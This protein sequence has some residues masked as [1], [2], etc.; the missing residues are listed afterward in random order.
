MAKRFKILKAALKT[1]I[2]VGAAADAIP[3]APPVGTILER[4]ATR[5]SRNITYATDADRSRKLD[6]KKVH[7]FSMVYSV[8]GVVL[9]PVSDKAMT[10]IA[11]YIGAVAILNHD[12]TTA[13]GGRFRGFEP[14]KVTVFFPT[15]G[16][17]TSTTSKI[18]GRKYN[19]RAGN[20]KTYPFGAAASGAGATY[21]GAKKAIFDQANAINSG[22]NTISF[23]PED[24][25]VLG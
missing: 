1:L 13:D 7:P 23:K 21:I 16:A 11:T 18:S 14:A 17:P 9:V 6:T 10:D 20:S 25:R 12:A 5:G 24:G 15:A 8:A 3:P 19:K 2:P 4:F 22:N